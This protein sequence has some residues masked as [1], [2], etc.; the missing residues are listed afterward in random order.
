MRAAREWFHPEPCVRHARRVLTAP[1][2]RFFFQLSPI[3]PVPVRA[4]RPGG[5]RETQTNGVSTGSEHRDASRP[6]LPE[7]VCY[8]TALRL[9]LTFRIRSLYA[10]CPVG[11]AGSLCFVAC[12]RGGRPETAT[13]QPNTGWCVARTTRSPNATIAPLQAVSTTAMGTQWQRRCTKGTSVSTY[14]TPCAISQLQWRKRAV[15]ANLT[16][17]LPGP[18]VAWR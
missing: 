10:T 17:K 5:S 1:G 16:A 9:S 13:L 18:M 4:Q 6:E 14:A 15:S 11:Q 3:V 8:Q 12:V 7:S 2:G